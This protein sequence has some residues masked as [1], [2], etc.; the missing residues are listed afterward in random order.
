M[1]DPRLYQEF[2]DIGHD[3]FS[4]GLTS[5]HGGNM[6]VRVGDRIIIKRRGG[7][8]ARLK[9]EDL[10]ET[11][12]HGKDSGITRASTELIV[13]RAIYLKTSALAVIHAHPRTAIVLSLSRDEIIPIDNE[14]SYLLRK[15]P[16]VSVEY[17]S[18]SQEMAETVSDALRGYKIIMQR[19]HG[20]F[21]TGQTLEEAYHWVSALEEASDIILEAHLLGEQ[22]IEYR[23]HSEGYK[24]W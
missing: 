17:A 23:K 22:M 15:I 24:N 18:G 4:S 8:F 13:H 5:S 20:C 6:S 21:S 3:I 2:R 9:P 14:G 16:V 11:S 10:V 7:Q 1:I 19:G 12:L